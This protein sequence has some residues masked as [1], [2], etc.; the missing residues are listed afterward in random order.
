MDG[1]LSEHLILLFIFWEFEHPTEEPSAV[2]EHLF[3]GL[4]GTMHFHRSLDEAHTGFVFCGISTNSVDVDCFLFLF[5]ACKF[6]STQFFYLAGVTT[7]I[8]EDD[9]TFTR[10]IGF[11]NKLE[12]KQTAHTIMLG[13][14]S[15]LIATLHIAFGI[16]H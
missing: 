6:S 8:R 16:W 10:T 1:C 15:V 14:Q 7:I 12:P 2:I 5:S 11:H 4:L 9:F 3:T 13:G